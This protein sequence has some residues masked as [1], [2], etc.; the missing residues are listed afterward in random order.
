MVMKLKEN[1]IVMMG[2]VFVFYTLPTSAH[3]LWPK[4]IKNEF[5]FNTIIGPLWHTLT[6]LVYNLFF[7]VLYKLKLPSIEQ[8]KCNNEKWPWEEDPE[9]WKNMFNKTLKVVVYHNL[10]LAPILSLIINWHEAMR[11]RVSYDS[12]PNITEFG[13]QIIFC[14]LVEDAWSYW[15]HRLLHHKALYKHIHK[16]HHD[17]KVTVSLVAEYAHPIEFIFVNVFATM[18]GPIILRNNMHMYT[19]LCWIA[20]RIFH[21]TMLHSGYEFGVCPSRF[22][23]VLSHSAFHDYHHLSFKDNYGS[24]TIIWDYICRTMAPDY[25]T[26]IKNFK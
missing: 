25:K 16:I 23:P 11:P 10:V 26:K 19:Q 7:L 17:H 1:M 8:F 12:L 6:L 20:M 9:K 3:L 21:T 22:V 18:L 2:F 13:L 5:L 24:Y 15:L 14:I 4:K